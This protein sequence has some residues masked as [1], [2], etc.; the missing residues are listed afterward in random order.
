MD[1]LLKRSLWVAGLATFFLILAISCKK[2]SKEETETIIAPEAI[3]LGLSVKWGSFN[4]GATSPEQIG[5]LYA[6]GET[7]T[8]K[9]YTWGNY[10]HGNSNYIRKYNGQ[11]GK[12]VLDPE[13]DVAQMKLGGKWRMPTAEEAKEW[14][15]QIRRAGHPTRLRG[16]RPAFIFSMRL[17]YTIFACEE[18]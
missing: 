4:L 9:K 17:H 11:D 8:K 2:E 13:D 15:T 16:L 7:E 14:Q 3:D 6:W 10:E 1:Y 5:N 12:V 18:T